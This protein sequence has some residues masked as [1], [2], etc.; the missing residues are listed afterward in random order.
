MDLLGGTF[1]T[2]DVISF[3]VSLPRCKG[4]GTLS[5]IPAVWIASPLGYNNVLDS[6]QYSPPR[7]E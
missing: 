2:C 1:Y 5:V 3:T 4:V 7:E 6:D